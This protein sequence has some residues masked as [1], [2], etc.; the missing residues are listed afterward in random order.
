SE[1]PMWGFATDMRIQCDSAVILQQLCEAVDARA[2][3]GYR[4]RITDRIAGWRG[5]NEAAAQKRTAAAANKG[6][7][8]AISPAFVLAT[9]SGKISQDDIVLNEAIRNGPVLQEHVR[10]TRPQSYV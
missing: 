3:D 6:V 5:A 4:R 7:S 9:V 1:F 10:R 8:G 2:D